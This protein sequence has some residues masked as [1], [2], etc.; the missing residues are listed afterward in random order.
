MELKEVIEKYDV[1]PYKGRHPERLLEWAKA[2]R[3]GNFRQKRYSLASF[4]TNERCCLGVACD[5]SGLGEWSGMV[6]GYAAV[7]W[8]NNLTASGMV[9]PEKVSEW[10]GY[11]GVYNPHIL[12]SKDDSKGM[13]AFSELNDNLLLSFEDIAALIEESVKCSQR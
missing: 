8:S 2:L 5:I 4:E 9:L 12:V 10:L 11:D 3:S 7:F 13:L 1:I 6:A